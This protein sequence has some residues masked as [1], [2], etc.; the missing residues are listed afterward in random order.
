MFS[1]L[2]KTNFNSLVTF[3]M[4]SANAFNLD[5]SKILSFA[6]E[7]KYK[8]ARSVH[9]ISLESSY[10]VSIHSIG[11]GRELMDFESDQSHFSGNLC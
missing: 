1:S 8:I 9:Q 6:K 11:F 5:Q 4:L 10:L 2:P 3:I 7:L